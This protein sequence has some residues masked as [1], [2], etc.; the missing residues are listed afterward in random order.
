MADVAFIADLAVLGS[1][2]NRLYDDLFDE[3]DRDDELGTRLTEL[4]RIGEFR[5][6]NDAEQVLYELFNRIRYL[7]NRPADD[8]IFN[9]AT[10]VHEY[11]I[12]SCSQY[13]E[14][15]A[16]ALLE[17][18][19]GK[20]GY[21]V[22]VMFGLMRE[23]MSI[24]EIGLLLRL[25]EVI[26]M[27]DDY[28]DLEQDAE[29]GIRT[30]ATEGKLRLSDIA[31]VLCDTYPDFCHFYGKKRAIRFWTLLYIM[32]VLTFVSEN[33]PRCRVKHY[34]ATKGVAWPLKMLLAPDG[35]YLSAERFGASGPVVCDT[36]YTQRE[37][38]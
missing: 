15:R 7:L 2:F 17:T 29:K 36:A 21:A 13:D 6:A 25:G 9:A 3:F 5:P 33:W 16:E 31:D 26:Q 27:V 11:Q 18:T 37:F 20:G 24:E 12:R 28:Q 34:P 4:F 22:V 19:Q 8:P 14:A 1:A 38:E 35:G 23:S 10:A 32:T 30:L